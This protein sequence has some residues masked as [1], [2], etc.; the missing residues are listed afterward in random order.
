[1]GAAV[2]RIV[3]SG[4]MAGL[5]LLTSLAWAQVPGRASLIVVEDRGGDSALPYFRSLQNDGK[6]PG[7]ASWQAAPPALSI[8]PRPLGT[9][10]KFVPKTRAAMLPLPV[11]SPLLQP[12]E[13]TRRT[14]KAPNMRPLFLIG[15]DPV[16][17]AW[18]SASHGALRQMGAV[19]F[20]VH[21]DTE[22]EFRALK[23]M[24]PGVWLTP[25]SGNDL[26]QRL[27]LKTYPVLLLPGEIDKTRR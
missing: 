26:A 1:M 22:E 21:L 8:S 10:Q 12:G 19:G 4:V 25:A 16:S 2:N 3:P 24:A 7:R 13:P 15:T 9:H 14:V 23:E 27:S 17:R 11:R 18:L 5:L 6:I 20:V